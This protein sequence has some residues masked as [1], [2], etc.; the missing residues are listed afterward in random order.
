VEVWRELLED[1]ALAAVPK[2][3][4]VLESSLNL[5]LVLS[6]ALPPAVKLLAA[7][8]PPAIAPVARVEPAKTPATVRRALDTAMLVD[9]GF[10]PRGLRL[11][12]PLRV[13]CSA[14]GFL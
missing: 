1:P 6:L 2:P 4:E 10:A 11:A 9:I 5:A 12:S 7:I 3:D 14:V 8:S 13:R